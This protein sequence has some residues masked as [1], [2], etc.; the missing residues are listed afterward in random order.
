[1]GLACYLLTRAST[2]RRVVLRGT[3][4]SLC[5][6]QFDSTVTT[7][8]MSRRF[9]SAYLIA[10][11]TSSQSSE[12]LLATVV[13]NRT[14]FMY[15]PPARQRSMCTTS[16]TAPLIE[17]TRGTTSRKKSGA[18]DPLKRS[19]DTNRNY[20]SQGVLGVDG[21]DRDPETLPR[22]PVPSAC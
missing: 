17:K 18:S 15:V 7:T 5:G 3:V 10:T 22:V 11:S 12:V 8:A 21:R 20:F 13:Y 9:T 1:M 2:R 4:R 14:K 16:P 19:A 6:F